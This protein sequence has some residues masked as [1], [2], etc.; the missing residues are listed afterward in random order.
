MGWAPPVRAGPTPQS[1]GRSPR[2]L[3]RGKRGLRGSAARPF[4][5]RTSAGCSSFHPSK[6]QHR[7]TAPS[8][9]QLCI[10]PGPLTVRRFT[11]RLR[12]QR[13]SAALSGGVPARFSFFLCGCKRFGVL[14]RLCTMRQAAVAAS[15]STPATGWRRVWCSPLSPKDR[16]ARLLHAEAPGSSGC[17]GPQR[18]IRCS[19]RPGVTQF[20][21]CGAAGGAAHESWLE[22]RPVLQL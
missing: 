22:Q 3:A 17:R 5:S 2:S 13:V 12:T 14:Q 8:L 20:A 18:T 11:C 10:G 21:A 6:R 7:R 15:A 19:K 1:C 16:D 9:S 4:G